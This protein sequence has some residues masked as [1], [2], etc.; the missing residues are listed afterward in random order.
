MPSGLP[1]TTGSTAAGTIGT[2]ASTA[3]RLPVLLQA[4]TPART[5]KAQLHVPLYACCAEH[6]LV[7]GCQAGAC[8]FS[9]EAHGYARCTAPGLCQPGPCCHP[10]T[11][12]L[13]RS[14][15]LQAPSMV[16]PPYTAGHQLCTAAVH[17]SNN[18]IHTIKSHIPTLGAGVKCRACTA[19]SRMH[20][21]LLRPGQAHGQPTQAAASRPARGPL[22]A[23]TPLPSQHPGT[24]C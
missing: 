1:H 9:S 12:T 20:P 2:L 16:A 11:P 18:L 14:L 4:H 15:A 22:Q 5:C 3:P 6:N 13:R 21:A 23:H 19:H 10:H 17:S 7:P 8:C 24:A